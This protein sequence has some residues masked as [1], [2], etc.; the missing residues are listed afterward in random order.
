MNPPDE[1]SPDSLSSAEHTLR[2]SRLDTE[3]LCIQLG[4]VADLL[5]ALPSPPSVPSL[6]FRRP[7]VKPVECVPI[8]A[9]LTIGRGEG[10]EVRFEGRQ[11]M[12]RRHFAVRPEG[13]LFFVEDLG[14]S[15]GTR[16]DGTTTPLGRRELRDGDII[17]A[18]GIAFVF[19][20]LE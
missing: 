1:L 2:A 3:T 5:G 20:R 13:E 12:S 14:S 11:E 16:V 15:N 4:V 19:V 17:R 9:G 18:G 7:D 10:C 8:G 6:L